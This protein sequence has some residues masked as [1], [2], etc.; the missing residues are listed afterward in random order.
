MEQG[1]ARVY[2]TDK[3]WQVE[4]VVSLLEEAEIP[5]FKVDKKDSSYI[6]GEIDVLVPEERADEALLILT[7]HDL[8]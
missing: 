4:I 2:S 1:W 7:S 3:P 5:T 6:F 8:K